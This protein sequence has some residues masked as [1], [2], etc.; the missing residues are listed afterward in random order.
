MNTRSKEKVSI[1]EKCTLESARLAKT[2]IALVSFF[3]A[4]E[5]SL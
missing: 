1:Y 3:L 5:L 4:A 2:Q